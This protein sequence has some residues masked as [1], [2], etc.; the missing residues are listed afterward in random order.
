MRKRPKDLSALGEF[1]LIDSLRSRLTPRHPE[2]IEGVGNDAA[3]LRPREG[4]D[5]VF[6]TDMLVEH[7][8]FELRTTD[9]FSLGAKTI[10]VNLSDCAAMGAQPLAA[11]VSLGLPASA[12][13]EWVNA[14]Y[15]GMEGWA[16][17]F[18]LEI[19]GGDTVGSRDV[20]LNVALL[21]QVEKGKAFTRSGAREGDI[22]LVTG[23][24]GDSAGGLH[25]LRHPGKK[26]AE[27]RALLE[28][29]HR[30]PVPR[31]VASRFLVG[32]G[33]VTSCIDV[34]DGLSS[35]VNHLADESALGA[36]VYEE[37][38][39]L[40]G[41]LEFYCSVWGLDPRALALHGGEDYE[42]LFTVR[43]KDA[44][45]ILSRLP[46]ETGASVRAIGRMTGKKKGVRLIGPRGKAS[47]LRAKGYDHFAS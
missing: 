3:V 37:S 7:R 19:V 28:R 41:A 6:T 9:P 16:D 18:G 31:C 35:E 39:P 25:S 34:S 15:E 23:T 36:E 33:A 10:A 8:H 44:D 26:G 30:A 32:T 47:T 21:G 22:L 46:A 1:G 2:V 12:S 5:L 14:L 20:T 40:S 38:L 45:R 13:S 29:R 27:V 4:W 11:V 42:L 24:L 17:S 43:P